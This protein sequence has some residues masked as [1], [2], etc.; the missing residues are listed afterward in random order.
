LVS[1]ASGGGDEGSAALGELCVL[2]YRPVFHYI[3]RRTGYE[4][5][6]RDLTQDFFARLL[7]KP[8][9]GGADAARGKFRAFLLGAVKHFL[10]DTYDRAHAAKRGGGVAILPL[11]TPQ[12]TGGQAFDAAD[13]QAVMPDAEFDRQWALALLEQSLAA[14]EVALTSEGKALHYTVLKPWLAGVA[15]GEG[16]DDAAVRLG[17]T[18]GAVRVALHRL[19]QRFRETVRRQAAQTLAPCAD[20]EAELDHLRAVLRDS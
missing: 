1:R 14:L 6:A 3:R 9:L 17:L 11:D 2:Y 4:E 16:L 10:A 20:V 12:E 15:A 5:E 18:V 13:P 7:A 19:R 8:A